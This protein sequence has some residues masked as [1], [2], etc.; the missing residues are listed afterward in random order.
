MLDIF[1]NH[2][3]AS[4]LH[5][6]LFYCTVLSAEFIFTNQNN[7]HHDSFQS[8]CFMPQVVIHEALMLLSDCCR[9]DVVSSR[10]RAAAL[11]FIESFRNTKSLAQPKYIN[12][13]SASQSQ[14]C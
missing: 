14:R 7:D 11:K 13:T 6:V 1:N 10:T 4:R 2:F 12:M 5:F 8:T 9:D 3:L